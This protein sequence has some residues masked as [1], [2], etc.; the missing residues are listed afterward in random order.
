MLEFLEI[1]DLWKRLYEKELHNVC[2][3]YDLHKMDVDILLF[4]ANHPQC[5]NVTDIVQR[6][7]L[8]KSH[9]STSLKFLE[10]QGYIEKYYQEGNHKTIY[11]HMLAKADKVIADGRKAQERFQKHLLKNFSEEELKRM[12]DTFRR[13][14]ENVKAALKEEEETC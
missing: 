1:L 13:M 3:R 4:L 2:K 12:K 10:E 8:T 5:Q 6:R 14:N 7:K 9:V 11:L